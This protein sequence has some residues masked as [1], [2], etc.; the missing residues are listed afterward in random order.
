MGRSDDELD[1]DEVLDEIEDLLDEQDYEAA[2]SLCDQLIEEDPDDLEALAL[3]GEVLACV[4]EY[5]EALQSY[6]RILEIDSGADGIQPDRAYVLCELGR[7]PEALAAGEKALAADPQS[8]SS[9]YWLAVA[10]EL[11]GN[12]LGAE[13]HFRQA[14]KLNSEDFHLPCRVSDEEFMAI[15]SEVQQSFPQELK[16]AMENLHISVRDF[17][18]MEIAT[19]DPP[20]GMLIYGFFDGVPLT[21][22]SVSDAQTQGPSHIFLF[23]KNLERDCLSRGELKDEIDVTLK[24]EIGH[25]FGE[26]EDDMERLGLE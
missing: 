18:T 14:N 20:L 7:L 5:E 4:G 13:R 16:D 10:H 11:S 23:K 1:R 21:D 15:V 2:L 22:R 8:P 19:G 25:F 3:R 17:P 12:Q 6:D 24:H 9:H 26:D